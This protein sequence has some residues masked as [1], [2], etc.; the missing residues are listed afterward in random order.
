[1]V[2]VSAACTGERLLEVIPDV[3]GLV[4]EV[5]V[6]ADVSDVVSA[7]EASGVDSS[8]AEEVA[9]GPDVTASGFGAVDSSVAALV[10]VVV[11]SSMG[12]SDLEVALDASPESSGAN[13]LA[14]CPIGSNPASAPTA[15]KRL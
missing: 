10:T 9:E 2:V 11:T 6:S 3:A 12:G 15:S 7:A 8:D 1:M 13:D 4:D 5:A 14:R